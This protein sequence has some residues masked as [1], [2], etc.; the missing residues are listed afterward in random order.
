MFSRKRRRAWISFSICEA[1]VSSLCVRT[2][3]GPAPLVEEPSP[4]IVLVHSRASLID[5]S[6][7]SMML[8]PQM[9]TARASGLSLRPAHDWQGREAMYR[10]IS[11]RT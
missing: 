11:E 1:M 2:W 6:V 5:L 10:S 9:V 4:P 8:T 3:S 7:A